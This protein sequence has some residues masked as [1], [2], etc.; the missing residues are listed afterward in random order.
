MNIILYILFVISISCLIFS[1][2][3]KEEKG[4]DST[5]SSTTNECSTETWNGTIQS[6]PMGDNVAGIVLDSS[7][8]IF[9]AGHVKVALDDQTFSGENDFFL[10]K[11]NQTGIKQWTKT[12][13]TSNADQA[14]GLIID[15]SNN[16]YIFGG[17]NGSNTTNSDTTFVKYNSD[18]TFQSVLE[19]D[20]SSITFD[21][22]RYI[23]VDPSGN[24]YTGGGKNVSKYDSSGV[25]QWQDN[26]TSGQGIALDSEGNVYAVANGV[27]ITKYNSSGSSQWT[28]SLSSSGNDFVEGIAIDSSNNIYITGQTSGGL[29]GNT[30]EGSNDGFLIKFDSSGNKQWTKQFG[31]SSNESS[32]DVF[33]DNSGNV[34]LVGETSGSLDGNTSIGD[35]DVFLI[36][37]NNSGTKQWT[38][39]IGTTSTD[40]GVSIAVNS[41]GSTF[42][43]GETSGGID[44]NTHSGNTSCGGICPDMFLMKFNTDG[45]KQ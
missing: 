33:V 25:I 6:G 30:N 44:G 43:F 21:G 5:S 42:L 34:Y 2:S 24:I 4:D 15:S 45:V 12:K 14:Y 18:G 11:Y 10:Q 8:N 7:N 32:R 39:Q 28:K 17:Y 22:G 36:K 29:D 35:I 31:T 1:C 20:N 37:F 9:V 38:K 13:G 16:L 19:L 3:K 26:Q 40:R 41:C 23:K 27:R